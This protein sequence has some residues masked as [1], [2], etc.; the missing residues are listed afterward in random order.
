MIIIEKNMML[1]N[2]KTHMLQP[3]GKRT[4][5]ENLNDHSVIQIILLQE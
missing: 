1:I 2:N 5:N 4:Q 3:T